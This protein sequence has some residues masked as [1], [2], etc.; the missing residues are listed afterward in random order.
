MSLPVSAPGAFSPFRP[1]P[2][3]NGHSV[4]PAV[5]PI[6]HVATSRSK[7]VPSPVFLSPVL[8]E[9]LRGLNQAHQLT[10]EIVQNDLRDAYLQNLFEQSRRL[11][12]PLPC[13][14]WDLQLPRHAAEDIIVYVHEDKSQAFDFVNCK[15]ESSAKAFLKVQQRL[16]AWDLQAP[17]TTPEDP[18]Q[19][20]V[21]EEVHHQPAAAPP[22]PSTTSPIQ[23][24]RLDDT[25]GWVHQI[26]NPIV[27]ESEPP[28]SSREEL[29]VAPNPGMLT[30]TTRHPT[31]VPKMY[32]KQYAKMTVQ[33]VADIE[34]N[35]H[36][37]QECAEMYN[38]A[39]KISNEVTCI[40]LFVSACKNSTETCS[41][42]QIRL[43]LSE[44]KQAPT[45]DLKKWID[46]ECLTLARTFPID[47]FQQTTV[48]VIAKRLVTRS[49]TQVLVLP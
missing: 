42:V 39:Y 47:Q 9:R 28:M 30:S 13:N 36:S 7:D 5:I 8:Y 16:A 19:P 18:P 17:V 12:L 35:A 40:V 33:A 29:A 31:R 25:R 49:T 34:A 1:V 23:V 43:R 48:H 45:A 41:V 21:P 27:F 37:M 10:V 32:I 2:A 46:A 44:R 14:F 22:G 4:V 15:L 26:E 24:G 20:H 11:R 3:A 38:Y 6:P